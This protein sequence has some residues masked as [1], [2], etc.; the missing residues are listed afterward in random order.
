MPIF[1]GVAISDEPAIIGTS[2]TTVLNAPSGQRYKITDISINEYGGND[3]VFV[4]LFI[5]ANSASAAAERI[6]SGTFAANEQKTPIEAI[7]KGLKA[8]S[9]LIAKAGTATSVNISGTYTAYTGDEASE[10]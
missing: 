2:D 3:G 5:S 4:E 10:G 9:Y 7:N 6:W 1:S 8:G